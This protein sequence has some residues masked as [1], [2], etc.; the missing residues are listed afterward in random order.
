MICDRLLR[1]V[2]LVLL[3]STVL[4]SCRYTGQGPE[5]SQPTVGLST[6][7][8]LLGITPGQ[9]S[10]E[11]AERLLT[12]REFDIRHCPVGVC[13]SWCGAPSRPG[14][15]FARACNSVHADKVSGP[16]VLVSAGFD[17]EV[18][19]QEVLEDF[20]TPEKYL[21]FETDFTLLEGGHM[22]S[23][24]LIL[25]Y[26]G[27]GRV[28]E[29]WIPGRGQEALIEPQTNVDWI[30]CFL[31][32]TVER[33]TQDVPQLKYALRWHDSLKDWQGIEAIDVW[34]FGTVH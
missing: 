22:P 30:H 29:A 14:S 19:L 10:M 32:T 25:Y 9:T 3:M 24:L 5:G 12:A 15:P 7:E 2:S 1:M 13:V 4:T 33:L 26:T 31:P 20:G 6:T 11:E 28:F 17:S 18:S 27:Q 23:V 16:V 34:P 8:C 21:A